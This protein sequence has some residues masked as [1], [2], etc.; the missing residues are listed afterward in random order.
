MLV[1]LLVA[2]IVAG[3]MMYLKDKR[4]QRE[5]VAAVASDFTRATLGGH[6]DD[7]AATLC[8]AESAEF[9]K[10]FPT[11]KVENEGY[12]GSSYSE[13]SPFETG[14]VEIRDET[15]KVPVTIGAN[16]T[17]EIYLRQEGDDKAWKV[18][19]AAQSDFDAAG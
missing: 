16:P 3:V 17:R 8:E 9:T 11:A 5:A 18:C 12:G 15:A 13:E 19:A 10:R 1:L 6:A 14:E 2:A 4:E 7:V